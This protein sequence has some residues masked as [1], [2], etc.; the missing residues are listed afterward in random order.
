[1][2]TV[3][4]DTTPTRAGIITVVPFV[5]ACLAVGG[6]SAALSATGLREWYPTLVRP[7][8]APPD[9][10]FGPVWTVLYVMMGVAA[11]MVWRE[12]READV[13]VQLTLFVTQLLV[14]GAW[15]WVFFGLRRPGLALGVIGA[16]LLLIVMT[17]LAFGRVR[18]SAAWLMTPYLAWV[19]FAACL[20]YSFWQLNR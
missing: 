17:A 5:L 9:W 13:R 4:H 2:H 14:N 12:R 1:M 8:F 7:A 15:S 10:L 18:R 19:S 20:N 6:I 11:W 16:L 3:E